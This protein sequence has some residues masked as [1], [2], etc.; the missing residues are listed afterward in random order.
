LYAQLAEKATDKPAY[1]VTTLPS[2]PVFRR[3]VH[4]VTPSLVCQVAFS[5]WTRDGQLRHPRFLGLRT[6]KLARDV[7]RETPDPGTGG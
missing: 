7:V 4:W 2:A 5:E 1:E 3:G 6:D